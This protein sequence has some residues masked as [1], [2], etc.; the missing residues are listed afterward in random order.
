M[1]K[2]PLQRLNHACGLDLPAYATDQSAGLDLLAAIDSDT[3]LLPNKRILIPTGLVIALPSGYEAQ[4]RPRSGFAFKYGITV[5]NTPGTIDADYR[6]EIKILLIHHGEEPF[7]IQK[8]MRIAQL[9]IAPVTKIQW[10]EQESLSTTFRQ[11]KGFGS[12]GL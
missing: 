10:Q 4:I 2:V 6:G 5:L 11:E 8:G 12:T 7:V 3:L 9:V 1:I